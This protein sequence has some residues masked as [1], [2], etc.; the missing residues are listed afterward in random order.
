MTLEMSVE[1]GACIR[2]Y[3]NT[4]L[5]RTVL[6]DQAN[7]RDIP[8]KEGCDESSVDNSHRSAHNGEEQGRGGRERVHMGNVG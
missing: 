6:C 8:H 2:L 3:G 4:V 7:V 1:L 5:A